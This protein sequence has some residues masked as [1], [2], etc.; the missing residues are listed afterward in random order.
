MV[1]KVE[2]VVEA[3][4]EV[5]DNEKVVKIEE[6]IKGLVVVLDVTGLRKNEEVVA[7]A[8]GGQSIEWRRR[9]ERW[10]WW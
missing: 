2:G 7:V 10:L 8:V 9:K 1:W 4:E 5:D 3:E 6:E